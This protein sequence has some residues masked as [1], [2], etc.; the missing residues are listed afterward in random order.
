MYPRSASADR[1][2]KA[3]ERRMKSDIS[4][5]WLTYHMLKWDGVGQHESD[6]KCTECG[7]PLM[8]TELVTDQK[9]IGYEGY[10]CHADKQVTWV[11]VG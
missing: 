9:G 3:P 5:M 10:V 1:F 7:R 8:K 6:Q 2:D 4:P 11:K